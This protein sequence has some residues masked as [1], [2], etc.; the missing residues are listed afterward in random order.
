MLENAEEKTQNIW[1][2][3]TNTTEITIEKPSLQLLMLMEGDFVVSAVTKELA[4]L[5]LTTLT[6]VVLNIEEI[7]VKAGVNSTDG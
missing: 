7:L 3:Y 2:D 4:L 1:I 5:L 6:V